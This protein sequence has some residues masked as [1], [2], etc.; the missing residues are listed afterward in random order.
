MFHSGFVGTVSLC[1]LGSSP[2]VTDA[3]AL[4]LVFMCLVL[5][6]LSSQLRKRKGRP[7]GDAASSPVATDSSTDVAGSKRQ[8]VES[9]AGVSSSGGG[10]RGSANGGAGSGECATGS[11]SGDKQVKGC[12]WCFVWVSCV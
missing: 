8:R 6:S 5:P 2:S 7:C 10:K 12:G 1:V 9:F 3:Q 4:L 11:A